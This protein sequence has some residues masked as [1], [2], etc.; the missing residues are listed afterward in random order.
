MTQEIKPLSEDAIAEVEIMSARGA[1]GTL[2]ARLIA[3]I[4]QLQ[5][6]NK[7]FRKALEFCQRECFVCGRDVDDNDKAALFVWFCETAKAAREALK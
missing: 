4:R 2:Y 1:L 6:E 7:K 3:T 5:E